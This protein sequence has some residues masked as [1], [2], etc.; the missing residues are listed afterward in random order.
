M[1]QS[2]ETRHDFQQMRPHYYDFLEDN[3]ELRLDLRSLDVNLLRL[4]AKTCQGGEW[5]E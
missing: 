5:K 1:D 2:V 3:R 4:R